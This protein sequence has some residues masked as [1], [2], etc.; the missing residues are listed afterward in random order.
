MSRRFGLVS[1]FSALAL[2][3]SAVGC[4]T[5][6]E[7]DVEASE[8]AVGTRNLT[9]RDF[10]LADKELVLTLDDGPGP[11]TVELAEWL[12][13]EG[14]PAV[15]FMIGENARTRPDAV[16]R[17]VEI[18]QANGGLFIVA[19]HSMT[20][21]TALP[22]QGVDGSIS[23]IMSADDVLKHAI[24][25]SQPRD[26][27]YLFRPPYGAFTALGRANIARVNEAG[28][29]KYIG[30]V[31]WDIGGAMDNGWS[32]D[33]A[34][35]GR[36]S[37]QRCIDGYIAEA[38]AK[39]KGVI[40]AH[41]I[42][43]KTVDMLT[44]GR[45]GSGVSLLRLLRD[46]HGFK[47][48]SIRAHEDAVET[49]GRRSEELA[50]ST[51][52]T[53]EARITI[54]TGRRVVVDVS[55]T[56]A[57]KVVVAFDSELPSATFSGQQAVDVTLAPG[58]HFVTISAVDAVGTIKKQERYTFVVPADIGEG[59]LE[60]TNEENASCVR[61]RYLEIGSRFTVY[62]DEQPCGPGMH[63]PLGSDTCYR[64]KGTLSATRNPQLVGPGEWS[65]E[66]EMVEDDDPADRSK[67]SFT[68]DAQTGAI[69]NARR[70]DW[71]VRGQRMPDA[72]AVANEVDCVLG[73]WKGRMT[74][75][76]G[77]SEAF[78]YRRVVE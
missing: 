51:D 15:F 35:W 78:L 72:R 50:S 2:L 7:E 11:R 26:P 46:E 67:I 9:A 5:A 44:G 41:D 6:A 57:D 14:I 39:R 76:D 49:F 74:F 59:S 13:R 32:A 68:I 1:T 58:Q 42:H 45:D 8:D 28:A 19:N 70:Y 38:R 77:R 63:Q 27:I 24:E 60:D 62:H 73:Q 75:A 21:T 66:L 16:R 61:V 48:V 18:S 20:H 23:E 25:A 31:F 4:S 56:N 40:L 30:P 10:G 29:T 43:S 69:E 53:I 22:E 36:V 33:W 65:A 55:S 64:R 17:V 3:A 54:M 12:A 71:T 37:M 47:F 34:C 52:A